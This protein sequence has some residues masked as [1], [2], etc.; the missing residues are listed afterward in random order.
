MHPDDSDEVKRMHTYIEVHT[1]IMLC[2]INLNILF[3]VLQ[4]IVLLH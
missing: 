2:I 3:G 4:T 1:C